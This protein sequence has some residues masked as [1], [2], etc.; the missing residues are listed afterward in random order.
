MITSLPELIQISEE[1]KSMVTKRALVSGTAAAV[2]VPGVDVA[3][4]LGLLLELLPKISKRFGLDAEQI[5]QLDAESKALVYQ[6]LKAVGAQLAGRI[7]TK[8]LILTL[9]KRAG[10]QMTS[11]QV[12]KYIPLVGQLTAAAISFGLM[13]YIGDQHVDECYAVAKS[14]LEGN[15][16]ADATADDAEMA[17]A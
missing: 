9:I 17:P 7:I 2:P 1:C 16:G 8:D 4:D 12:S 13:K 11:K 6:A 10:L 15:P 3:V 14:V 5:E